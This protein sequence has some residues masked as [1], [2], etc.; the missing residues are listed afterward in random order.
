[1]TSF[2]TLSSTGVMHD[3]SLDDFNFDPFADLLINV[4][5]IDVDVTLTLESFAGLYTTLPKQ[6]NA[7]KVLRKL[8]N[9]HSISHDIGDVKMS[10]R[11]WDSYLNALHVNLWGS[12]TPV[13]ITGFGPRLHRELSL[14]ILRNTCELVEKMC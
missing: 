13:K 10:L 2:K 5:K 1:M 11:E 12:K 9:P 14:L 8:L 4:P 6:S 3:T 7:R